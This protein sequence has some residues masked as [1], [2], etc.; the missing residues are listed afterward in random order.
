MRQVVSQRLWIGTGLDARDVRRLHELEIEAVVDVALEEPAAQ[1]SRDIIYLR[2]PLTDGAANDCRVLRLAIQTVGE[3]VRNEIPTLVACGAGMSRSPAVVAAALS[4]LQS[5]PPDDCLVE[6]TTG[7][8]CDISPP[9][10]S[11]VRRAVADL[12]NPTR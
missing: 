2:F 11:D 12:R 8:P 10:W 4:H 9:L 3:L 6:L 5:R 7:N 1:L